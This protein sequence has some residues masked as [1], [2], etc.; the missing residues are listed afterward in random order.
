MSD[1]TIAAEQRAIAGVPPYYAGTAILRI[2]S[3]IF[4]PSRGGNPMIELRLEIIKPEKVTS[5]FDNKTYALDSAEL[6]S[7]LLLWELDTKGNPLQTGITW[8][9]ETLMPRLGL[10]SLNPIA[11][12][13]NA[14]KNPGG[15]KLEGV[16]F[17]AVVR[18][19]ERTQQ[20]RKPDGSYED[21]KDMQGNLIKQGWQWD[22]VQ[23]DGIL[24]LA[25]EETDRAF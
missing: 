20:R 9:N 22:N 18:A 6:M 16:C 14:E 7:W 19:K 15:V 13:Y 2:K 10:T 23:V 5:D 8:L 12:L 11:P 1:T 24:R 4:K 25:E 17:E 3:A 21:L